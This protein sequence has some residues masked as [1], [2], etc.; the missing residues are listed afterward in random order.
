MSFGVLSDG[1]PVGR[2]TE[3]KSLWS[4]LTATQ[5]GHINTIGKKLKQKAEA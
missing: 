1:N 2:L 3:A 4:E 5:Q